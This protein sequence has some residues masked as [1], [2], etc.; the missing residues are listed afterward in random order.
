MGDNHQ[1]VPPILLNLLVRTRTTS[2]FNQMP[3]VS[4]RSG[5]VHRNE[6]YLC[7]K[8]RLVPYIDKIANAI[9][10]QVQ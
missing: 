7:D 6:L 3:I 9:I 8:A 5:I 10:V 4:T 2:R 1:H